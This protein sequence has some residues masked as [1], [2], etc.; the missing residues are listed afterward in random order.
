MVETE[1]TVGAVVSV[2]EEL[3]E[4]LVELSEVLVELSEE[5]S[6]ESS[7]V[8]V[9]LSVEVVEEPPSLLLLQEM[10]MKLKRDMRTIYKTLFI[11]FLN[12]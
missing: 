8:E 9:V 5:S 11:F 4:V 10:T 12:Q 1:V 3:S 7:E 6:E 2:V